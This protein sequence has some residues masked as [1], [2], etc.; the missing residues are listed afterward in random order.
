MMAAACGGGGDNPKHV[1]AAVKA[2]DA[3]LVDAPMADAPGGPADAGR[4]IPLAKSHTMFLQTEGVTVTP[5]SDD[6]TTNKSSIP[7]AAA[8][9]QPWLVGDVDRATK[10]A[11]QAALIAGILAPYNISVVTTRPA[12][13]P[14]DMIVITDDT[15]V[16]LGLNAGIGAITDTG[17]DMNASDVG[18][19]FP[20]LLG[21]APFTNVLD[22]DALE[23][24]SMF[25]LQNGIPITTGPSDCMCLADQHCGMDLTQACTIGGAHTPI[26]KA[27]GGAGTCGVADATMDEASVFLAAFGPH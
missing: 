5:G 27:N 18:F 24:I 21:G 23:A 12:A 22:Y 3:R 13:G 26:D 14:Y 19:V 6:A 9:L 8:T 1:D 4:T 15:A 10:I 7:S 20:K 25:G 11:Q 2:I 16:K 17:C